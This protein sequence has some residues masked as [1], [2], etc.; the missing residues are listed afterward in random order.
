M[1]SSP[2]IRR[3]ICDNWTSNSSCFNFGCTLPCRGSTLNCISLF[4]VLAS[5]HWLL[6][7]TFL[8]LNANIGYYHVLLAGKNCPTVWKEHLLCCQ[9]FWRN[10]APTTKCNW[11]GWG[12]SAPYSHLFSFFKTSKIWCGHDVFCLLKR[13]LVSSIMQYSYKPIQTCIIHVMPDCRYLKGMVLGW[14][15]MNRDTLWQ[16]IMVRPIAGDWNQKFAV[17]DTNGI[18]VQN[19]VYSVRLHNK[20]YMFWFLWNNFL[21]FLVFFSLSICFFKPCY[22]TKCCSEVFLGKLNRVIC[23]SLLFSILRAFL[24]EVWK[25]SFM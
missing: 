1:I 10:I 23:M 15:G 14:S 16:I 21:F 17:E 18:C 8:Y 7:F 25:M 4:L 13:E 5:S 22:W 6:H 20:V 2:S 9:H 24:F 19:L 3:S 12:T 11:D